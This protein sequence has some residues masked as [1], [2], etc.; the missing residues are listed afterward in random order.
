MHVAIMVDSHKG[1]P[2]R[3]P[4][5][6]AILIVKRLRNV[7]RVRCFDSDFTFETQ[8]H[9]AD[10]LLGA[11]MAGATCTIEIHLPSQD[12]PDHLQNHTKRRGFCPR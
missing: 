11:I 1:V 10:A 12:R 9:I 8:K 4:S 5:A 7:A 6:M 3:W 2:C